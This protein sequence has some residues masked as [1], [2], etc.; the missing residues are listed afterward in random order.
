MRR[1]IFV[2]LIAIAPAVLHAQDAASGGGG[3]GQRMQQMLFQNITLSDQQ[4]KQID[5]VRSAYRPQ[6]QSAS[7]RSAR[8]DLMQKEAADF[9]TF[10]T[11][12]QQ[13]QFDKN[14]ADMR[15]NMRGGGSPQ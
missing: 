15:S 2:A 1:F 4:Q 10:L 8:R 13:T 9:R 6:M 7:D 11:P 3:R 5:S 14:I 12:D